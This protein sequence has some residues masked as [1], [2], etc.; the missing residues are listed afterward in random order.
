MCPPRRTLCVCDREVRHFEQFKY[1][2]GRKEGMCICDQQEKDS[3]HFTYKHLCCK[4]FSFCR[5]VATK[6][7]CKSRHCSLEFCPKC[8][9][10]PNCCY[11]PTCRGHIAPNF[12]KMLRPGGQSQRYNSPQ[13]RL[14]ASL[15]VPA[16]SDK[17]THH[18]KLLCKS[19]QE[20]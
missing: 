4:S 12:R 2:C 16:K 14:H 15:P 6:A 11:T 9:K 3:G 18:H 17:V 7:R 5:K 8:H 20:E 10:C 19:S 1:K 13:E